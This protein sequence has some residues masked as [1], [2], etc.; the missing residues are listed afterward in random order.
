MKRKVRFTL[1]FD[2]TVRTATAA[3]IASLEEAAGDD[4][5]EVLRAVPQER[6]GEIDFDADVR[7]FVCMSSMTRSFPSRLE[8]LNSIKTRHGGDGD[9]PFESI[10]GGPH[11]SGDPGAALHAGFDYCCVGEGEQTIREIYD[12]AVSGRD[13]AGIEGVFTLRDGTATGSTRDGIVDLDAVDPLPRRMRFPTYIEVG[14]GCRWGCAYCQTPRI[15]GRSERFRSPARVEEIASHYARWGM[16]DIRLLLPNALSYGSVEPGVPNCDALEELLGRV[17]ASCRESNLYL[18]SFPSE[19]RPDYVTPEAVSALRKHVDNDNLVIG[20]QSGSSRVLKWLDRGHTVDEIES[21]AE[22]VMSGGFRASVDLMLG[23]P[24]EDAGDREATLKLAEELGCKGARVNM[25]F[26]M[27]LPG[28]PLSDCRPRF[29]SDEERR[30]LDR[31]AQQ[32][33][34]RGHWRQQERVAK[35]WLDRE[36]NGRNR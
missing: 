33:I 1:V 28:T 10:I 9:A 35:S 21:A 13:P 29:L 30:R 24:I 7:E 32:G 11:A 23:F 15:F 18:G 5:A 4:F 26:I 27:P 2:R 22:C 6:L 3:L 36:E 25:H 34:V 8:A 16:N 19:V 17:R 14:R 12:N 31:L 20:G